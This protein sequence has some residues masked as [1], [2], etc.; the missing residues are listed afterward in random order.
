M[1]AALLMSTVMTHAPL[2]ACDP[3]GMA[4]SLDAVVGQ[5]LTYVR[6]GNAAALLGQM[7]QAG[8]AFGGE[9]PAVP[10]P[11]LSEMFAHKAGR[12]CDLFVCGGRAGKLN[13][14][15]NSGKTT[16]AIDAKHN[17]AT[18][19]L[20]ANTQKELDLGYAWTAQCRWELTSI[21]G[22]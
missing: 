4:P 6:S 22:L 21:S 1:I 2:T 12:Y 7:S 16:K 18:V 20:N 13:G 14:L 10:Y 3:A 19:T 11:V 8:V 17:L 15:F 9:G 5:T